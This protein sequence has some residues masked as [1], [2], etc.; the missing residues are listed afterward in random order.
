MRLLLLIALLALSAV[1]SRQSAGID[2][3]ST[4]AHPVLV[5]GSGGFLG[6]RLVLH[7]QSR[8]HRVTEVRGR[9][10]VDLRDAR[11][12]ATYVAREGP[13]SF[14]FFLACEV[15]GAKYLE[16]SNVQGD[17]LRHNVQIYET[18]FPWARDSLTPLLFS[19][20]YTRCGARG[21]RLSSDRTRAS[22]TLFSA[23][24]A[25]DV[26]V[27]R[28]QAS[29]LWRVRCNKAVGRGILERSAAGHS[30]TRC[31]FLES[32]RKRAADRTKPCAV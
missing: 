24:L 14:V 8:G 2:A 28:L 18:V 20:S 12:F 1:Y 30:W 22:F 29:A 31:T 21:A 3:P 17:I 15:G 7:L 16:R 19:S 26:I 4:A 25:R 9:S 13:F 6:R 11:A 10:H 23:L 32:V 5:L 27:A